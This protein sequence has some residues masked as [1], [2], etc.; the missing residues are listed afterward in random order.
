MILEKPKLFNEHGSDSPEDQALL[1]GNPSGIANL[2]KMKYPWVNPIYREMIGNTWFP[3][4]VDITSDRVTIKNLTEHEDEAAQLTLSFLIYMD[5]YQTA[6]LPNISQYVTDPGVRNLLTIQAYQEVIHSA[7]YQ[8]ILEALY[9]NQVR[10]QIYN[11]WRTKPE[12]LERNRQ[13]AVIGEMFVNE[14]SPANFEKACVANFALEGV[15]FYQGFNFFDQLSHRNR[16]VQ[17]NKITDYIKVDEFTHMGIFVNMIKELKINPNVIQEIL[18]NAVEAEINWAKTIYGNRI[19]GIS[20]AS[21]TEYLRWIGNDRL[22][23]VGL[24]PVWDNVKNPYAHIEA[25]KKAGGSRENFFESAAV[26][27]YDTAGSVSGWDDL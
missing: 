26:T 12:L 9:P 18:C 11:L 5:N 6:N 17:T 23:R 27:Q 13:I 10:D 24:G 14:P 8:Y 21:S 3:E 4:K 16:L 25:S 22:T 15:F 19:L 2:N 20:E 7:S 1:G